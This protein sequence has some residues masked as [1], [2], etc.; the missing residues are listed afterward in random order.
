MTRVRFFVE[1]D[2]HW[3]TLYY[4]DVVSSCVFRRQKTELRAS[5][6]LNTVHVSLEGLI[7]V[8]INIDLD[9]LT[10]LNVSDLILFEICGDPNVAGNNRQQ[11]LARLHQCSRFD[12][13]VCDAARL[14]RIELRI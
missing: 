5:S 11:R 9:W 12:R 13:L 3:H 1:H 6:R 7:G 8:C 4:F 10:R 14:W 2:L